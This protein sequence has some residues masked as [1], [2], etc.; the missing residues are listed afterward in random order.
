MGS[1]K[2]MAMSLP[3]SL[4]SSAGLEARELALLEP[5]R[6]GHTGD[7]GAAGGP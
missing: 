5:D 4:R 7:L 3:R 1:W 2:I 6:A